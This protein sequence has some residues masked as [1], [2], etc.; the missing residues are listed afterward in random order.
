[1]VTMDPETAG[2]SWEVIPRDVISELG[3]EMKQP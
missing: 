2:I 3:V 1:M